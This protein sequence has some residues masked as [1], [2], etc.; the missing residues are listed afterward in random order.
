MQFLGKETLV[1]PVSNMKKV[2]SIPVKEGQSKGIN[3]RL[4]SVYR[5][6]FI[7]SKM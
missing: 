6:K 2:Q 4:D 3:G 5:P 7:S 1:S